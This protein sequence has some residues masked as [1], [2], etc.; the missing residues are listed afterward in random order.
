MMA[1][2]LLPLAAQAQLIRGH[3]PGAKQM[4]WGGIEYSRDFD[5]FQQQHLSFLLDEADNFTF[6]TQLPGQ[7]GIVGV[8]T[9]RSSIHVVVERGKTMTVSLVSANDTKSSRGGAHLVATGPN[10]SA[11][12]YLN[13]IDRATSITAI[14]GY[15]NPEDRVGKDEGLR[16][17]DETIA[18]MRQEL[19]KVKPQAARAF[20]GRYTDMLYTHYR[21]HIMGRGQDTHVYCQWGDSDYRKVVDNINPNDPVNLTWQLPHRWVY[22]QIDPQ[23]ARQADL[24][25]Y[26][27]RYIEVMR[28]VITD[29]QVRHSLLDKLIDRVVSQGNP[30]D[31]DRFWKPITDYAADDT[32]LLQKYTPRIEALRATRAGSMAPDETFSDA[33]GKPCRL[34]DLRGKVLYIDVWA[35]WCVPCKM[36]IPHFAR[37]AEHYKDDPAIQLV[38]ISTDRERDHDKWRQMIA[39]EK[40]A[41]P[42]YVMNDAENEKF[43]ADFNIQFIPR[44]III[45][46]DGTIQNADAPRPSDKN[47]LQTLDAIIAKN[48]K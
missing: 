24:T 9:D 33:D 22:N 47:I 44:F 38:S 15:G 28:P 29:A 43:S 18:R 2:C 14:T 3:I 25:D 4:R 10:K 46:A 31:V 34:S 32:E 19:K 48:K 35:T 21:L 7:F 27:L 30:Q 41:W 42:Q 45:N 16:I 6:D 39:D 13:R 20:M 23:L 36:E 12:D 1:A 8:S 5:F 26:A 11:T 17:L 37:V 40:P